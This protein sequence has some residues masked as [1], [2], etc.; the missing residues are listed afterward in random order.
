MQK[1]DAGL[2]AGEL[3]SV[4]NGSLDR[5]DIEKILP[6]RDPFLFLDSVS[7]IEAKQRAA[8]KWL[9]RE[10]AFFFK[11]HFPGNPIMPGVLIVEAMA[12]L[13]GVLMLNDEDYH[14]KMAYFVGVNN[15]KFRK[16]VVPGNELEM[17]VVVSK[18]KARMGIIQATAKVAGEMVAQA[19]LTF[20]FA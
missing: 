8:G 1:G 5:A 2:R 16:P 15:A 20:G 11:G 7:G 6:H 4:T 13:A 3:V 12:Q 18:L 19:N 9:V 17:E 14:H 10:D